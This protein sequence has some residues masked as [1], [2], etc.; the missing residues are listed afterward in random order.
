MQKIIKKNIN[1]AIKLSGKTKK[2]VCLEVGINYKLLTVYQSSK[3]RRIPA[4]WIYL[5]AKCTG[6]TTDFIFTDFILEGKGKQM[7]KN[8]NVAGETQCIT[9]EKHNV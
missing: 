7:D 3:N 1:N 2:K 8:I 4:E 5:I 6:V 9:K